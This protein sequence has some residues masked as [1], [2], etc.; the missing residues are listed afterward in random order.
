MVRRIEDSEEK[1]SIAKEVLLD[2]PEWFGIPESTQE[3]ID[4]SV[5]MP[6]WAF[7]S[8][9]NEPVGFIALKETSACTAEVFVIGVK[10]RFHRQGIGKALFDEFYNYAKSQGYRFLQVKTVDEGRYEEY[11]ATIRFY[12]SLGF[13]R[14]EVFPALW[15]AHNPCLLLVMVIG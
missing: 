8:A 11:D 1:R 2:L 3:Y 5:Q 9:Q 6:F 15:D 12:E 10:K 4:E 14:L 13:C 7:F